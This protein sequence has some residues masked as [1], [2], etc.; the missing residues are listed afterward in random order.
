MMK[1]L[2]SDLFETSSVYISINRLLSDLENVAEREGAVEDLKTLQS[3]TECLDKLAK[4]ISSNLKCLTEV[5]T[6]NE[7][8]NSAEEKKAYTRYEDLPPLTPADEKRFRYRVE[9]LFNRES[10]RQGRGELFPRLERD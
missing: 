8:L 5:K 2:P 3:Q 10:L 6:Y 4:T 9:T 1:P 7:Q